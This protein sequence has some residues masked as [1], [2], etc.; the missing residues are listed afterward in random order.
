MVNL[1]INGELLDQYADESVDIV[2]SVLDVSD[3]TKNTGDYSKSCLL[4]T[5]PSPRDS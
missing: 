1:F 5:S 4:Y 2:S 3:I